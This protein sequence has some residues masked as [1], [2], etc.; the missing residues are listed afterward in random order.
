[1]VEKEKCGVVGC[2]GKSEVDIMLDGKI[3]DCFCRRHAVLAEHNLTIG[4]AQTKPQNKII[5]SKVV[6]V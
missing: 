3:W 6:G 2:P 4:D 5:M 1:M